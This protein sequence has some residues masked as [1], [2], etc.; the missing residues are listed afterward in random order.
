MS[1]QIQQTLSLPAS[2]GLVSVGGDYILLGGDTGEPGVVLKKTAGVFA[3]VDTIEADRSGALSPDG[4]FAFSSSFTVGDIY[5]RSGDVFSSIASLN[6]SGNYE[7]N[8]ATAPGVM[9]VGSYTV[10]GPSTG[11]IA[12][13]TY[14]A[15]G[16]DYDLESEVVTGDDHATRV[17]IDPTG[18]YIAV[19]DGID[20]ALR[21][22]K[23]TGGVTSSLTVL[24]EIDGQVAEL[25]FIDGALFVNLV[26]DGQSGL[27][28][29]DYSGDVFTFVGLVTEDEIGGGM[30]AG[31][32]FAISPDGAVVAERNGTRA[33]AL[34]AY[35]NLIP[36]PEE[37]GESEGVPMAGAFSADGTQLYV[38]TEDRFFVLE[39]VPPTDP[40]LMKPKDEF[41]VSEL[42]PAVPSRPAIPFRMYATPLPAGLVYNGYTTG[43]P[44]L[45]NSWETF[46]GWMPVKD[47]PPQF[48]NTIIGVE[49]ISL[50]D[51]L[52]E[53]P[54]VGIP[55][56]W[57]PV[58][59]L[60]EGETVL[61]G[62]RAPIIRSTPAAPRF[63]GPLRHMEFV[64][65]SAHHATEVNGYPIGGGTFTGTMT[66]PLEVGEQV[67]T[68][69]YAKDHRGVLLRIGGDPLPDY[70]AIYGSARICVLLDFP[71]SEAVPAVPAV[72]SYD[73]QDGWNAGANGEQTFAGD[74]E[75]TFRPRLHT[76]IAIGLAVASERTD[77]TALDNIRHAL[78]FDYSNGGSPQVRVM[79][80]G[81]FV[82]D[83]VPYAS[84]DTF[85][86][87]RIA[88]AVTFDHNATLMY[89]SPTY[90]E[91]DVLVAAALYRAED[92][93]Y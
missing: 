86:I 5:R 69:T 57:E 80:S 41:Q 79:E 47:A 72:Y 53:F 43:G 70:C 24:S 46:D 10:P 81:Q 30:G 37:I 87:R 93:I 74:V 4:G 28:K 17:A 23:R 55:A 52:I 66:I 56:S 61:I 82:T 91:G 40:L 68:G 6:F 64:D 67:V 14:D 58:M 27:Y 22:M 76:G 3:Q 60:E 89:W 26:L 35:E 31:D 1:W 73:Y 85:T 75:V 59:G 8:I 54:S 29:Y 9:V 34:G 39:D 19:A 2:F 21:I 44:A 45:P 38:I 71:G 84:I 36:F 11:R 33:L 92:G 7:S 65:F 49:F 25:A 48:E 42:I 78:Y 20:F 77:L 32:F 15:I 16:N 83:P 90:L 63:Y 50:A 88:G 18:T 51:A 13:Y 62:Y 12:V